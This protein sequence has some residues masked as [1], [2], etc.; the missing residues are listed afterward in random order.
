[1][2]EMPEESRKKEDLSLGDLARTQG[3]IDSR[4]LREALSEQEADVRNGRP[5]RPL[6]EILVARGFLTERQVDS[7]VESQRLTVVQPL[8]GPAADPPA[9]PAPGAAPFPPFGKYTLLRELGHGGMGVVYEAV[10]TSLN[11]KV[12]LKTM[13]ET[14]SPAR[15]EAR[16]DEERF[17]REA[18]LTANLPRHPHIVGVYE[19]GVI[20]G[21]RYLAMEYIEGRPMTEWKRLGS[22]SIRQQVALLRDVL[23]AVHHAHEHG[24]IHRDLKPANVLVDGRNQP[25]V[26]DF[27]LAKAVGQDLRVS[28]TASG[29]LVGTPTYMSPEQ[30]QALKTIDRRTDVYAVG[31]MLYELLTGRPPFTGET[32][33]E[34]LMKAVRDPVPPPSSIVDA[35]GHPAQDKAAEN[36]CLKALAKEPADRYPTAQAFADDLTK[37]LS[38]EEVRVDLPQPRRKLNVWP[39][40]AAAAV[41]LAAGMLFLRPDPPKPS[42]ASN[43]PPLAAADPARWKDAVDLLSRVDPAVDTVEGSWEVR[44]GK[45][46]VRRAVPASRIEMPYEPPAEYDCRVEFRTPATGDCDLHLILSK[47]G[48]P[49]KW[50]IGARQNTLAGFEKIGDVWANDHPTA[51]RKQE[52]WLSHDRVYDVIVQVRRDV[53]KAYLDGELVLA[54]E[55]D[56]SNLNVP[57]DDGLR[58]GRLLGLRTWQSEITFLRVD[59]LEVSGKGRFTRPAVD[60]AARWAG[61]TDLMPLVDPAKDAVVGTWRRDPE[62]LVSDASA[63]SRLEIPYRPPEEYDVR[64]SFTPMGLNLDVSHIL[65][66]EGRAFR[67]VMGGSRNKIFGF[68]SLDG[69]SLEKSPL[70]VW[71]EPCLKPGRRATSIVQVRKDGLRAFLDGRPILWVATDYSRARNWPV[72]RLRDDRALGLLTYETPTVFHA[73]HVLEVTGRGRSGRIPPDD[74]E[75]WKGARSLLPLIEPEKDAILG[76]WS[77]KDGRLVPE[78][79]ARLQIPYEPPEE[80]DLLVEFSAPPE[81]GSSFAQSLPKAGRAFEWIIGAFGNKTCGFDMVGG[82]R[83]A[84]HRVLAHKDKWLD[85]G[86]TYR[87]VVQVRKDLVRAWLNGQLVCEWRTEHGEMVTNPVN[88]LRDEGLLGLRMYD[89]LSFSRIDILELSGQGRFRRAAP[90]KPDDPARWTGAIDVGSLIDPSQDAVVGKW[91]LNAGRLVSDATS[92][93]RIEVPYRPPEEYD[94]RAIFTRETGTSGVVLVLTKGGRPFVFNMG[95]WGNT[96]SGFEL[97]GGRGMKDNAAG[98]PDRLENGRTYT[99][100]VQVRNGGMKAFVDGKQVSQ[101]AT[102]DF[103]DMGIH[104]PLRLRDDRLLGVASDLGV[105]IFHRLELLEV[106]GKGTATRLREDARWKGAPNLLA[107]VDPAK[108]AVAGTWK[109]E[110][111]ALEALIQDPKDAPALELPYQP[112]EEYD[113]RVVFTRVDGLGDVVQKLSKSGRSFAWSMG[114]HVNTGYGFGA[115]DGKWVDD[116]TNPSLVKVKQA[117]ANGRSHTSVVQVRHDGLRAYVDGR[118]ACEWRTDYREMGAAWFPKVRDKERLGLAVWRCPAVFHSAQVLEVTGQG[119][120]LR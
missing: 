93:A 83:F 17:L 76:K 44:D 90:D 14:A 51:S 71:S 15:K 38:G 62:G 88:R 29:M 63:L 57:P 42:P 23:L 84:Q 50:I 53:L 27:G 81:G 91:A 30:A 100:I 79:N 43:A 49:F 25:H 105:A 112:P 55:T 111:G 59:V 73:I 119:K 108:D 72:C 82:V 4:Q 104:A 7:L 1:V 41:A 102:Q 87:S 96:H 92:F 97:I 115:I 107:I 26:V 5:A 67:W 110:A 8:G 24:V 36:I 68:D 9:S 47:G 98:Y 18:H 80:Y 86:A 61:A 103:Q 46:V 101:W 120:R 75:R 117:L 22:V 20:D 37:W 34:L 114:A 28:L 31:V 70:S 16:M 77:E 19:A 58:D 89:V 60:D 12:A 74:P 21:R 64:V 56:G 109:L 113:Y 99:C 78:R 33:I 69:E 6:G 2:I 32:A 13:I 40:V 94:L 39:Y 45:L 48:H 106:T 54:F 66:R 85:A 11:R 95:A 35:K 3:F 10:D 52:K 118:L 116:T 65:N